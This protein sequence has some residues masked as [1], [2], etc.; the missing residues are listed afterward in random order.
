MVRRFAIVSEE[1]IEEAFLYPSDL[2]NNL[3]LVIYPPVFT[4]PSG[5]S[6]MISILSTES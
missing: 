5:D 3:R 6:C 4:S 1:E 2:A